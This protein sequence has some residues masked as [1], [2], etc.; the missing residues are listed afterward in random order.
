VRLK[1]IYYNF[2]LFSI[3]YENFLLILDTCNLNTFN[4]MIPYSYL[5]NMNLI[6]SI[7]M[8]ERTTP[9]HHPTVIYACELLMIITKAETTGNLH[10]RTNPWPLS[11]DISV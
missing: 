5:Q 11:S 4:S 7:Q 6:T 2:L 1:S 3:T 8:F 10:S 9:P